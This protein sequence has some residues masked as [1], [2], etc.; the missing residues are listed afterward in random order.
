MMNNNLIKRST[1]GN[2]N[3]L[4]LLVN[5]LPE[6]FSCLDIKP[7]QSS[8]GKCWIFHVD[9]DGFMLGFLFP[10]GLRLYGLKNSPQYGGSFFI[11]CRN[12]QK[13]KIGYLSA[14]IH[15][16]NDVG[17]HR[18]EL[19]LTNNISYCSKTNQFF[20]HHH[21]L[22]VG[23][24]YNRRLTKHIT[25]DTFVRHFSMW[26]KDSLNLV[27]FVYLN[28]LFV[29][30]DNKDKNRPVQSSLK[31]PDT[32]CQEF[33]DNRD[34]TCHVQIQ[35]FRW[36]CR[37][38]ITRNNRKTIGFKNFLKMENT[39]LYAINKSRFVLSNLRKY[40]ILPYE[41]REVIFFVPVTKEQYKD[42]VK[43]YLK[44]SPFTLRSYQEE[45]ER[46]LGENMEVMIITICLNLQTKYDKII[47][48]L[49]DNI[50]EINNDNKFDKNVYCDDVFEME[51]VNKTTD[52]ELP[53]GLTSVFR[54]YK[55]PFLNCMEDVH[56][57]LFNKTYKNK[58]LIRHCTNHF[59]NFE[60]IG[61]RRSYQ[62]NGSMTV[63]PRYVMDHQ[64]YRKSMNSSL[65]PYVK[66]IINSLQQEALR[67]NYVSG[68]SLM[69][70][71]KKILC[72]RDEKILCKQTILTQNHFH[73]TIHKDNGSVL[74]NDYTRSIM[75]SDFISH[76]ERKKIWTYINKIYEKNM[77]S[78]PK[79]TTC[80]W[81]LR[82]NST[83]YIMKQYFVGID[84]K[85][86]LN[87]S[88]D[89]LNLGHNV[90][91]TFLSS[92]FY[93]VTSSPIWIDK[94]GMI[95]LK[96]PSNMY[97]FAWGQDGGRTNSKN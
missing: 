9:L 16:S 95:H 54:C 43:Q 29:D 39:L 47:I 60:M 56:Y 86:A 38:A 34:Q 13:S 72:L 57:T 11:E 89:K 17:F 61:T 4:K 49:C 15:D 22:K 25:K 73:N 70:L 65:L 51:L 30:S 26:N 3:D 50:E 59:G 48:A 42:L 40:M 63:D 37:P 75:N 46:Y 82:Q 79:S 87:L 44:K 93:H 94:Q 27:R 81:S 12:V 77:G 23:V 6:P 92:M 5:S 71:Y 66:S 74:D 91:A 21:K 58:G 24:S 10:G 68:E 96:G 52:F 69:S 80:C 32:W 88:S 67:A 7:D 35:S 33:I 36:R 97:N 41:M 84:T 83:E 78:L 1:Y 64:Y 19:T 62:S 31:E 76:P 53:D 2:R 20:M 90:G 18:G 8:S 45:L 55:W 85:F 14:M 28:E